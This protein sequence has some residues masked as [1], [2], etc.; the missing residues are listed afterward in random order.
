MSSNSKFSPYK[1][2]Y[3]FI[4]LQNSAYHLKNK[5][6]AKSIVKTNIKSSRLSCSCKIDNSTRSKSELKPSDRYSQ[7]NSKMIGG[8]T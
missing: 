5:K 3:Q 2:T 6:E 8:G 7:S 1:R 4:H